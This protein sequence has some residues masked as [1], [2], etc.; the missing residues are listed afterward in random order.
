MTAIKFSR[1]HDSEDEDD[2]D[3]NIDDKEANRAM[4]AEKSFSIIPR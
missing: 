3:V 2:V 1:V 4:N